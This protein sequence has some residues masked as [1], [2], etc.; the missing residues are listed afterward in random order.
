MKKVSKRVFTAVLAVFLVL[1]ASV[2]GAQEIA[3]SWEVKLHGFNYF[4]DRTPS[5][6]SIPETDTTMEIEQSGDRVTI[7]FGGFAGVSAATI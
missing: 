6:V 5:K 3:G 4:T 1:T 2:A 7:T